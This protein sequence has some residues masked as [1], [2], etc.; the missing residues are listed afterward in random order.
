MADNPVIVVDRVGRT[1]A[2]VKRLVELAE[3][4]NAPV[5]DQLGRMNMP[6]RHALNHTERGAQALRAADVRDARMHAP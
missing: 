3:T 2:G 1:P 4:L 6:N 5:V